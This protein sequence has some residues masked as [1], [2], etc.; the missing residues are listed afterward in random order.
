M[1]GLS[2]CH[3]TKWAVEDF[4]QS[5][6]LDIA[7]FSIEKTIVESGSTRTKFVPSAATISPS[8]GIN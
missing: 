5:S 6:A 1:P 2:L 3:V 7:P 4:F 8:M